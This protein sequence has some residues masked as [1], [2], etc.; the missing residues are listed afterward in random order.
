MKWSDGDN[1]RDKVLP[2]LD[3]KEAEGSQLPGHEDT[4][5]PSG[6]AHMV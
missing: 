2:R 4:Q 5:Q 3:L 1:F 6:E